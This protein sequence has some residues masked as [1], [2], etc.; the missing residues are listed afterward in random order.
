M[1]RIFYG[2]AGTVKSSAVISEMK[3]AG[4]RGDGGYILLVP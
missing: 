3:A 1:L 2:R 4:D